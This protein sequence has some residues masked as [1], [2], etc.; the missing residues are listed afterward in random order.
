MLATENQGI[1]NFVFYKTKLNSTFA[2]TYFS[3]IQ[4]LK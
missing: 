3:S 2:G 1:A 4:I